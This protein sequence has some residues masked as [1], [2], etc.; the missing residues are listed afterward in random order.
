[1]EN[2]CLVSIIIPVYNVKP[3]LAEALDSVLQQTYKNLEIILVDDGSTDGSGLMCDEYAR[4]DERILV[5]H[6]EN[7]GLSGARNAGMRLMHGAFVAFLDSDDTFHPDFVSSMLSVLLK[8]EADIVICQFTFTSF[9]ANSGKIC[10]A[11]GQKA[12]AGCYDKI[13]ALRAYAEHSIQASACNKLF[14]TELW[15]N[16]WFPEG[17]VY[18][19]FDTVYKVFYQCSKL[20]LI[21][22]ALYYR[23][24][25]PGSITFGYSWE[26]FNDRMLAYSH[27]ASFMEENT[28]E[29]FTAEHI[30]QLNEK[31]LN[32]MLSF[33]ATQIGL[34]GNSGKIPEKEFRQKIIEEGKRIGIHSCSRKTRAVYRLLCLCPF[35]LR[36]FG[37]IY[38]MFW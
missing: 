25:R 32:M 16:I 14:R 20:Y 21:D 30:K 11:E 10:K 37:S 19:D 29:I 33:Y 2:N 8:E 5:I 22:Q 24:K 15:K 17:H 4:K 28:P 3:Y 35:L 27:F 36:V 9:N 23:R 34:R 18:E 13:S 7:K 1:M 6:Q 26:S 12:R 31:R 38:K